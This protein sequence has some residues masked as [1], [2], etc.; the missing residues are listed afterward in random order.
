MEMSLTTLRTA[1]LA[2][3]LEAGPAGSS[4]HE[5]QICSEWPQ[6]A[7]RLQPPLCKNEVLLN[8]LVGLLRTDAIG[9]CPSPSHLCPPSLPPPVH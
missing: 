3:L 7:T 5:R 6:N 4:R 8:K 1:C 9:C 2:L